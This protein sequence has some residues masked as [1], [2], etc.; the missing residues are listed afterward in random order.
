MNKISVVNIRAE[1]YLVCLIVLSLLSGCT[2]S[3]TDTSAE[4]T[5]FDADLVVDGDQGAADFSVF[6]SVEASG[7]ITKPLILAGSDQLLIVQN[8]TTTALSSSVD[9]NRQRASISPINLDPLSLQYSRKSGGELLENEVQIPFLIDGFTVTLDS[10][11]SILNSWQILQFA[12]VADSSQLP[13]R[14]ELTS[15]PISCIDSTG[16]NIVVES[17][18][19]QTYATI[20][21]AGL[22]AG[23]SETP[24][25]ALINSQ[26]HLKEQSGFTK[27]DFDIQLKTDW[28]NSWDGVGVPQGIDGPVW[29]KPASTFAN[30]KLTGTGREFFDIQVLSTKQRISLDL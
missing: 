29:I 10:N 2:A 24:G 11:N 22:L 20:D 30:E 23:V 28:R 16:T 7:N 8:S 21:S 18:F 5:F 1:A 26:A 27:C 13:V 12:G 9:D 15:K 6:L 3:S 4:D 19:T 17:G 25:S 14:A